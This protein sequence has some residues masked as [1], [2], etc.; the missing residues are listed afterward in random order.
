MPP[1][2]WA[3]VLQS[4][5]RA[6]L[7][8][9]GVLTALG[10]ILAIQKQTFGFILAALTVALWARRVASQ[11]ALLTVAAYTLALSSGQRLCAR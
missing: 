11:A 9:S 8:L 10:F 7:Y 3:I 2:I 5:C 4:L 6:A 1:M